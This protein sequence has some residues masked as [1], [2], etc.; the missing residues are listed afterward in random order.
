MCLIFFLFYL[1]YFYII[2]KKQKKYLIQD[3]S[4]S[5]KNIF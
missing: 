3:H 5:N 2:I 1:F 4:D